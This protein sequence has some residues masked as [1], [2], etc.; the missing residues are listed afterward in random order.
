MRVNVDMSSNELLDHYFK[1]E[2]SEHEVIE[3]EEVSSNGSKKWQPKKWKPEYEKIVMMDLMGMKGYEIAEKTGFTPQHIYNI[4]GCD[5][6]IAIQKALIGKI[7]KE[8]FNITDEIQEIQKL[9][10]KRLKQSLKDDNIF[11]TSRLGFI[12]KGIDVMKG[13]GEH[14]KN[15]PTN[16][17]INQFQLPPS[18]AD[19]FLAGL[20][21]SDE[22]RK[23]LMEKNTLRREIP[24]E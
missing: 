2:E 9:T 11:N 16:Q 18:V 7:R 14:L 19:R 8:S 17:V 6:A 3:M 10:V 23:L 22:A 1:E 24:V 15:A 12:A 21:K 20:E 5:E 13:T 4:L